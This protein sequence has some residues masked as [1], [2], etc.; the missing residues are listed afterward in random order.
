MQ[1]N[2][3]PRG[4]CIAPALTLG[5]GLALLVTLGA[6]PAAAQRDTAN[7]THPGGLM[8]LQVEDAAIYTWTTTT[9]TYSWQRPSGR[10]R[11]LT[12]SR[13]PTGG[14]P[15]MVG[16]ENRAIAS[17]YYSVAGPT[18][19]A[20]TY[21]AFTSKLTVSVDG[22][23]YD[24][25]ALG[26]AAG[27]QTGQPEDFWPAPPAAGSRD[28]YG[29]G[30]IPLDDPDPSQAAEF[31][32]VRHHFMLIHDA[33]RIDYI[34]VNNSNSTRSVGLRQLIDASFG[35]FQLDG[36][37]IVLDN[38]QRIDSE[39]VIPDAEVASVPDT[40]VAYDRI[41]NPTVLLRG[42][43]ESADVNDP[44][45]ANY[46]AGKP[47]EIAWGLMRSI[48]ADAQW[49]FVP[50]TTIPLGGQDWAYAAKWNEEDLEAGRSR[51]YVTYFGV[52]AA[53]VDFDPPY[54][55]AAYSPVRLVV[56]QG[57]DPGTPEVEQYYLTDRNGLSP[58]VV[59]A[60]ADNFY[61][62]PLVDASV[63]ISL[64]DGFELDPALQSFSKS[65]GTVGRNELKWVSWTVRAMTARPGVSVI[66]FTGPHGKMVEREIEIPI[67]PALT[68]AVSASGLEMISIPY[69]FTDTSVEWV[70]QSLGSMHVG[71]SNGLA[72]WNPEELVYRWFPHAWVSNI[73]PGRGYWLLNKNRETVY[74]PDDLKA[75]P[76]AWEYSVNLGAGWNQIGTPFTQITYLE[77]T[78][79]I[80]PNGAEWSMREAV[81]RQL[82]LPTLFWYDAP[83]NQYLWET[84]LGDV[85]LSPYLGHWLFCYADLTLLFTPASLYT[86]SV[87][88][89][90]PAGSGGGEAPGEWRAPLTV[91]GAGRVR[92]E[93]CFG[94][95]EAASDELDSK[96]VLAPP[97]CL[98]DGV[99]LTAELVHPRTGQALMQD[100]R[101]AAKRATEWRL[102]VSTNA[103]EQ[104]IT[105]SWPDLSALPGEL[106]ATLEDVGAG[107]RLHM[108]T[109]SSYTYCS[110]AEGGARVFRIT[111]QPRSGERT[112]VTS[113]TVRQTG[114]GVAIAYCLA[115]E[116]SVDVEVRNISGVLIRKVVT[117]KAS[118]AGVTSQVWDGRNARGL[119]A[120]AGRYL[121]RVTARSPA[122][123]EQHGLVCS[124]QLGR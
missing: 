50:N 43:L 25:H 116:A 110:P 85:K 57:D 28:V 17:R 1:H 68:P 114:A 52:G 64:P 73:V 94:M 76:T 77:G 89:A 69:E 70:F 35:Q 53:S 78:R 30:R 67:I 63:R 55:L 19:A 91:A 99:T 117:G 93:R 96:D 98:P 29:V 33:V 27:E 108:R 100:I 81:D 88:S 39:R 9:A 106:V 44:G 32:E 4:W 97:R 119:R 20:P 109:N 61:P 45:M 86:R 23:P 2:R 15:T 13:P 71:G 58:F 51:R 123:G 42:T 113:A 26:N 59:Y 38:G 21:D 124:F 14:N 72:R 121:C 6:A 54:A 24:I 47:D 41:D 48:G 95:A 36:G 84:E 60:Y 83:N 82:L 5:V 112:L 8:T 120:P 7:V 3:D 16:D 92:S 118:A 79:V 115:A 46:S 66:K 37:T 104:P 12:G 49:N 87:P 107:K 31:I 74:F 40:W 103:G 18:T 65:L 102:V 105:I 11:L 122:T 22:Q 10:F 111:V 34:V 90:G 56:Q 75:V 80:D 101:K 62:S